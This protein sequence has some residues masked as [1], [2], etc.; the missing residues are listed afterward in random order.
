[1]KILVTG[2]AGFIG[3]NFVHLLNKK[4]YKDILVVDNLSYGSDMENLSGAE[5]TFAECDILDMDK[6]TQAYTEFGPE[7]V[8]HFAAQSHVDRSIE[9]PRSFVENNVLGTLNIL[10][11]VRKRGARMHH[12]STDEVYG[13]LNAN[14]ASWKEHT[15]HLPSSP[16]SASKAASDA[17]VFSYV[18]TYNIHCTISN[19]SNNYGIRQF[20][21]K[22]IPKFIHS[23][24]HQY[25]F[26][27]YGAGEQIRDWIHVDDHNEAVFA[28]M[29][30]GVSGQSYNIGAH[31]EL[32]N[33]QLIQTITE[34]MA[35]GGPI[36]NYV[37]EYYNFELQHPK[38]KFVE[39]RKGHDFRYSVDTS[40]I[41][42]E[43]LWK[44]Q[45][46]FSEAMADVVFW[47][48]KKFVQEK[49]NG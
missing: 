8:V 43:L 25:E 31:V 39:D 15:K 35:S 38:I 7:F 48:T 34:L 20:H 33:M 47:Y 49:M 18:R 24:I 29:K 13:T 5:Y 42:S 27:V 19:C 32:N 41:Q 45:M 10:E 23:I 30:G 44:P 36:A 22:L 40:K 9:G 4:G 11:L 1:M 16:Y 46:K 2:G 6:L 17:L 28:I 37:K 3:S 14:D 26:G 12:I 21:E